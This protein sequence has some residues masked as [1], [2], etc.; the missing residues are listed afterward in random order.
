[1]FYD[2]MPLLILALATGYLVAVYLVLT[3]GAQY[4]RSRRFPKEIP[5]GEVTHPLPEAATR[6]LHWRSLLL[7]VR[8]NRR[9]RPH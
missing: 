9:P 7:R 2:S 8:P 4:A 1:M 5:A 3:L 6:G